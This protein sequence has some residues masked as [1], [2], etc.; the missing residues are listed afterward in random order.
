MQRSEQ[1]N[2][3][4]AA[5]AKAQQTMEAASKDASNPFFKSSYAD[6]A[7]CWDA[8]RAA[9]PM[10][11]LALVQSPSIV[12]ERLDEPIVIQSDDGRKP[13]TIYYVQHVSVET[14]VFHTSGQWMSCTV[15]ILVK[16][17]SAQ[18]GIAGI[19]YARRGGMCPLVGIAPDDDDD[20][21]TAAKPGTDV[22][23]KPSVVLPVCPEC[24]KSDGVIVGKPEYGGGFVCFKASG[25]CGHKWQPSEE[26]PQATKEPTKPS[27]KSAS[28]LEAAAVLLIVTDLSA[29][30]RTASTP[31]E[32]EAVKARC[33]AAKPRMSAEQSHQSGRLLAAA[34]ERTT[35]KTTEPIDDNG[36][37]MYKAAAPTD[38][39]AY[40]SRVASTAANEPL[41]NAIRDE[42]AASVAAGDMTPDESAH[43]NAAIDEKLNSK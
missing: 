43:V 39:Q 22:Y 42:I 2:E 24:G 35:P 8:W 11:G 28:E 32:V 34:I 4:A 25:G 9:G 38:F 40:H 19:T 6:L 41:M 29:D 20:G 16:D 14:T 33:T 15:D 31:A 30:I 13:K 1:I 17:D 27:T 36:A 5:L 21:N 12:H 10:N 26:K 37:S 3:L 18:A 7:D 23:R